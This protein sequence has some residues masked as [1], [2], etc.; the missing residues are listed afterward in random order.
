MRLEVLRRGHT[1]QLGEGGVLARLGAGAAGAVTAS[2]PRRLAL[3]LL[4]GVH[5]F[6]GRLGRG[7]DTP[8]AVAGLGGRG[9]VAALADML[10]CAEQAVRGTGK[11]LTGCASDA[12]DGHNRGPCSPAYR[13]RQHCVR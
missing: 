10:R 6:G 13:R 11:S 8:R 3:L 9:G 4:A 2:P 1:G 5:A 7:V 12:G